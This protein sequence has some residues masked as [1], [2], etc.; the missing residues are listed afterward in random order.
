MSETYAE[1]LLLT[2]GP[3][4]TAS[5]VKDAM[6]HDFAPAG[7][8]IKETTARIRRYLVDLV[9]GD[10][11]YECVPLQG[12]GTYAIE[13]AFHTLI[14]DDGKV[15]L[16]VNGFYGLRLRETLKTMG[17]DFVVLELPM[18]PLPTA[19]DVEAA[20]D[21]DP[22]ITHMAM[23]H[24]D[25]GTGVLNPIAEIAEVAK[26]R[27]VR[28]IVDAVASFGGFEI[29]AKALDLEAVVTGANKCLESAPGIGF[30]IAK[31]TAL[32]AAKGNSPSMS[33]D[34][35][36]QWAFMEETGLWRFTP[37]THV[38]LAM[39]A[40]LKLHE[41][42]GGVAG[43]NE[44]YRRVWRRLVSGMRQRGFKSLL[45]DAAASPIVASFHD[46]ADSHYS[47]AAFSAALEKRG[48]LIFAGRLTAAG[49]FRMG[50]M[51]R[52]TDDDIDRLLQAIEDTVEELGIQ[53]RS[54]DED[55]V[56]AD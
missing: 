14:P 48:F 41:R 33:L 5:E 16:V 35:H 6:A 2:P 20:L 13:A 37:P 9:N 47:Y 42:E 17:K 40:A 36:D 52:I 46:P 24:C 8:A 45:P 56:L 34:A 12:S 38:I 11:V 53:H 22:A 55:R 1:P 26:K 15:L 31:R 25:T 21:A 28:F 51:G 3:V 30:V 27:G 50:C 43:R 32:E 23:C 29:D 18:L 19:A 44:R 10:G 49:T 54:R 7:V 4:R 39:G